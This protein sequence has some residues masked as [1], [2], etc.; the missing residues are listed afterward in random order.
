MM[1]QITF[2]FFIVLGIGCSTARKTNQK[3]VLAQPEQVMI[4]NI[5]DTTIRLP[6]GTSQ[7]VWAGSTLYV[8]G[9]LDPDMKIHPTTE[10]QTVGLLNYLKKFLESQHLTLGD[11][12]MI[13][14]YLGADPA[15]ENKM[16]FAG[17]M[18]GYKQFFGTTEQPN[19]PARTTVQVI[20]PAAEAGALIEIDL[21]AV[22][23]K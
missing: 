15:K 12:V 14:V 10:Q 23:S 8:S 21:I 17:M 20:L 9:S 22:R 5:S 16:D 19:K 2:L 18:T 7:A 13:R 1:K 6:R 11:V 4:K 3:S